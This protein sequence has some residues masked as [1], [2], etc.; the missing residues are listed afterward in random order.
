MVEQNKSRSTREG[1][2]VRGA[3]TIV[4]VG[5]FAWHLAQPSAQI[6]QIALLLLVFAALPWL[7]AIFTGVEL[8]G[9]WKFAFREL[10]EKVNETTE[11]VEQA[12][13]AADQAKRELQEAIDEAKKSI[14]GAIDGVKKARAEA[15]AAKRDALQAKGGAESARKI[16]TYAS[17]LEPALPD[18]ARVQQVDSSPTVDQLAAEYNRIRKEM[19]S[20]DRRTAKMTRV[21]RDLMDLAPQQLDLPTA[22]SFL[23]ESNGGK[24]LAAYVY[25]YVKRDP[26][27]LDALVQSVTSI[28][29][30]P[31]GQYW[32]IRAIGR[33]IEE[34]QRQQAEIST[35]VRERLRQYL[36]RLRPGWDRH[37]ELTK[38]LEM[39][40]HEK[41]R[42]EED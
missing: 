28:E 12:K 19:P 36:T 18:E 10:R 4:A 20:G 6:D 31:F 38:I 37:Y 25:F 23:F 9:G 15:E 11:D 32:G 40:D 42:Q 30:K 33:V 2:A 26:N 17:T 39:F 8:P 7:N 41:V 34:A 16:A 21:V 14:A 24:R 27:S 22:R 35:A 1:I 13:R 5:L 29:D 3:I